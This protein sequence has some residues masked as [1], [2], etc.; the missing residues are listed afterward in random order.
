MNF[1]AHQRKTKQLVATLRNCEG[2]QRHAAMMAQISG[3]TAMVAAA[4]DDT[5]AAR[6][7]LVAFRRISLKEASECLY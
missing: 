2:F 5:M 6:L 3:D 1:R 4:E 7:V